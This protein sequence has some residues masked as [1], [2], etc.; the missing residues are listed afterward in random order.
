MQSK[1]ASSQRSLCRR[2][3]RHQHNQAPT[4]TKDNRV[5]SGNARAIQ[6]AEY[7]INHLSCVARIRGARRTSVS[8]SIRV[9][10]SPRGVFRRNN[11]RFSCQ[12]AI[13]NSMVW[14]LQS[15]LGNRP[16]S[17]SSLAQQHH[18]TF[19]LYHRLVKSIQTFAIHA[20]PLVAFE[21]ARNIRQVFVLNREPGIQSAINDV[22]RR[23]GY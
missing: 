20:T 2:I 7:W 5:Q 10:L 18:E 14:L 22:Y 6:Q 4:D 12:F 17:P 23:C 16:F 9:A 13:L 15:L 19:P 8:S 21:S 1:T 3:L 11:L